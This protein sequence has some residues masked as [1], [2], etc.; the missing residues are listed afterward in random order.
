[1]KGHL[2]VAETYWMRSWQLNLRH[3]A[4]ALASGSTGPDSNDVRIAGIRPHIPDRHQDLFMGDVLFVLEAENAAF[5]ATSRNEHE[6]VK[7]D[8]DTA[9]ARIGAIPLQTILSSQASLLHPPASQVASAGT[10][11]LRSR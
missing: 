1:M 5:G 9:S 3:Y 2:D 7:K 10:S 8:F 6:Q 4:T 11:S